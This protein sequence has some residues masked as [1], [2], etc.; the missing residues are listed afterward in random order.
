MKRTT[1]VWGCAAWCVWCASAAAETI[2]M[3]TGAR[4]TGRIIKEDDR[5]VV[6]DIPGWHQETLNRTDIDSIERQDQGQAAG[7]PSSDRLSSGAASASSAVEGHA[8]PVKPSVEREEPPTPP[9]VDA[10]H[11]PS[12]PGGR[13]ALTLRDGS[14]IEGEVL[15]ETA[16]DVLLRTADGRIPS[17]S[18]ADI[19][20]RTVLESAASSPAVA[21]SSGGSASAP[22]SRAWGELMSAL[23]DGE[24]V[25]WQK[26]RQ[27]PEWK[28]LDAK[29]R[30]PNGQ[31]RPKA[32]QPAQGDLGAAYGSMIEMNMWMAGLNSEER[33]RAMGLPQGRNPISEVERISGADSGL[34]HDRL[35][36]LAIQYLQADDYA[37][38]EPVLKRLIALEEQSDPDLGVQEDRWNQYADTLEHLGK[39]QEAA[40]IRIKAQQAKARMED[41]WRN[42]MRT[43]IQQALD[44]AQAKDGPDSFEMGFTLKQSAD[45]FAFHNM[46]DRAE[47]LYKRAIEVQEKNLTVG[48]RTTPSQ[49]R[50]YFRQT[51]VAYEK[52]LRNAGRVSEADKLAQRVAG[53]RQGR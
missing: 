8:N 36:A 1:L 50:E 47:P 2:R 25:P 12:Q 30:G 11:A 19:Q 48:S 22:F 16:Q 18:T 17:V 9:K 33:E 40:A 3:K 53:L 44:E 27:M 45:A 41:R 49:K 7:T 34:A 32:M 20:S 26:V 15:D 13:V 38:A 23:I 10:S 35:N 14:T 42:N 24:H 39:K 37:K 52:F 46:P 31:V 4:F 43:S 6:V 5:Q 28:Q 29:F 51:L 21:T